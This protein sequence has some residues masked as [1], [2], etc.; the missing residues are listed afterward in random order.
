M[1]QVLD[2][3]HKGL[4][5]SCQ[6]LENEPLH[7]SFIMGRMAI[8]AK[9]GGATCIR[10]NGSWSG[11]VGGLSDEKFGALTGYENSRVQRYS[12]SAELRPA[13]DVFEGQT[14]CSAV[15]HGC[16]VGWSPF[17]GDEQPGLIFGENTTG[18]PKPADDFRT[19]DI[20]MKATIIHK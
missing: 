19:S 15:N 18:R 16:K 10:H 14:G 6:A 9:E 3:I 5:V 7:S 13:N 8:A 1:Q 20:S 4:I 12:Q 11:D 2:K 17:R